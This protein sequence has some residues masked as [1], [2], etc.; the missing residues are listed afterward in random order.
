MTE[1]LNLPD[2]S[3]LR[4]CWRMAHAVIRERG[5]GWPGGLVPWAVLCSDIERDHPKPAQEAS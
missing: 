5:K 2:A 4:P 3:R 1:A